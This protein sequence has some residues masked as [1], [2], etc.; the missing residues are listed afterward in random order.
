MRFII[1]VTSLFV[2][3]VYGSF[4]KGSLFEYSNLSGQLFIQCPQSSIQ[5]SCSELH[6]E[7]W[8]YDIYNGPK[9][10][11]A[12]QVE[13]LA[14]ISDSSE[15]RRAMVAYDGQSGRSKEINLGVSTLFQRPLLRIGE[16]SISVVIK[17]R[18]N[19]VLSESE[20]EISVTRGQSRACQPRQVN[21]A[22]DSDCNSPYSSCQQY[23]IDQKY[24]R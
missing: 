24:C 4:S 12:T 7:P 16:N 22:N 15:V 3:Q 20:F 2:S 5:I 11:K 14:S 13:F 9:T 6:M 10:Q 1:L 8:P 19:K 18:L 17:D 23:F 21:S